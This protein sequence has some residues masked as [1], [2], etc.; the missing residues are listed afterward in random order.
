MEFLWP[1]VAIL[2]W[3]AAHFFIA[4]NHWAHF[5]F[6]MPQPPLWLGLGEQ[7]VSHLTVFGTTL[8]RL[9]FFFFFALVNWD[10][11]I[12]HVKRPKT[13]LSR[14]AERG[15]PCACFQICVFQ[16]EDRIRCVRIQSNYRNGSDFPLTCT[17][18]PVALKTSSRQGALWG[19]SGLYIF[20]LLLLL[21]GSL[22]CGQVLGPVFYCHFSPPS[23]PPSPT[24]PS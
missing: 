17:S 6:H 7:D 14:H 1:N 18:R 20:F 11:E 22:H 3:A 10:K 15:V 19:G 4:N 24:V 9:N 5:E 8:T 21:A 12:Y 23:A 16:R 13:E 2:S